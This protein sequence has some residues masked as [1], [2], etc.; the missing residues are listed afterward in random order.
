MANRGFREFALCKPTR[1]I[2][3][4]QILLEPTHSVFIKANQMVKWIKK[5]DNIHIK[6][7]YNALF[8]EST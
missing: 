2:D 5:K 4:K 3:V 8:E 1:A 7:E 6:F